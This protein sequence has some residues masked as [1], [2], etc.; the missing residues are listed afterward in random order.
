[1]DIHVL[2]SGVYAETAHVGQVILTLQGV[3]STINGSLIYCN[4]VDRTCNNF[5][6]G[7]DHVIAVI[8]KGEKTHTLWPI[9]STA[10]CKKREPATTTE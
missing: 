3:K 2:E 10:D 4:S 7:Y 8:I 5:S 9:S 6:S 1:M